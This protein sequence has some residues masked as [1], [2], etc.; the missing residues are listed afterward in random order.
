[1]LAAVVV[2]AP[3]VILLMLLAFLTPAINSGAEDLPL[4]VSA[5]PEQREQLISGLEAA[6]PGVFDVTIVDDADAGVRAVQDRDAIGGIAVGAEATRG[7]TV[8]AEERPAEGI[9]GAEAGPPGDPL[10]G[11]GGPGQHG[12][13]P[14]Q[15]KA[16]HGLGRGLAAHGPVDAVP[17]VGREPGDPGE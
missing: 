5:P 16:A 4:T 8:S 10:Q 15:A 12:G 7:E 14:L 1:M 6:G 17:V 2:G 13:R 9:R 3:V 11:P